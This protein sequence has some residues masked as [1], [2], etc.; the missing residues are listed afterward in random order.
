MYV[1]DHLRHVYCSLVLST[2]SLRLSKKGVTRMGFWLG[3]I[4]TGIIEQTDTP[5][6]VLAQ[7][8]KKVNI[9]SK[10][11]PRLW[12]EVLSVENQIFVISGRQ[13]DRVAG[14]EQVDGGV[15]PHLYI[16]GLPFTSDEGVSSAVKVHANSKIAHVLNFVSFVNK[17]NDI[18]FVVKRRLFEAALTSS[19]WL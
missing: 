7:Y 16:L 6:S 18:P 13:R 8:D 4:Y 2:I 5:F 11:L 9:T 1:R 19:L 15:V 10:L 14:G 17:N 3:Y 12:D